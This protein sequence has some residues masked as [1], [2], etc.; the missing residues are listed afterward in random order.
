MTTVGEMPDVVWQ[1]MAAGAWD[2]RLPS[3]GISGQKALPKH[4][5]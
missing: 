5:K 3:Y 1:V 2:C 4:L